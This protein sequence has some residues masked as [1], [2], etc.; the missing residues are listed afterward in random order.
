MDAGLDIGIGALRAAR[1]DADSPSF[2]EQPPVALAVDAEDLASIDRAADDLLTVGADG[3]LHVLGDDA[4]EVGDAIGRD[5]DPLLDTGYLTGDGWHRDAFAALVEATLGPPAEADD[6]LCYTTPG[7]PV[8][9]T[10]DTDAHREAVAG[11]LDDMGY[12]ATPV[13]EGLA[14]IYDGLAAENLTGLGIAVRERTTSVC[15]AYY[16]VP[17]LVFSIARG[18]E[19]VEAQAAEA[20][21]QTTKTAADRRSSFVLDPLADDDDLGDA[22]GAAYDDLVGE[23]LDAV[24]REAG[25]GDVREGVSVPVVLG[26]EGAVDGLEALFGARA[27]GADLP[28]SI[29]DAVLA[30]DPA[31]ATARGALAAAADDVD[32][33]EAVT[34]SDSGADGALDGASGFDAEDRT[35]ASTDD[36]TGGDPPSESVGNATVGGAVADPASETTGGDSAVNQLFERLDTR[37]EEIDD[38]DERLDDLETAVD[39]LDARL[40]DVDETAATVTDLDAVRNSID[41]LRE[42]LSTLETDAARETAVERLDEAVSDARTRIG[43]VEEQVG[44]V[45]EQVETIGDELETEIETVGDRVETAADDL[46]AVEDRVETVEGDVDALDDETDDLGS[47]LTTVRA[48]VDEV[49]VDLADVEGSVGGV[50]SDVD[51]LETDFGRL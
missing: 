51:A 16:G 44:T 2:D 41:D 37:D 28:F 43:T 31:R 29:T 50:E 25:E 27:E 23:V 48:D 20:T 11:V 15:L 21:G 47:T 38:L 46:E 14:V 22:L 12:D 26:G 40:A 18:A 35:T 3:R 7:A 49:E 36:P 4:I 13:S 17:V 42:D 5:P 1:G 45:E 6:H 33:Y 30:D 8:D 32:A 39:A 19:W 9:A 10:V 24:D 34:W